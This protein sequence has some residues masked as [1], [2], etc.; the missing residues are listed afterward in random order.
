MGYEGLLSVTITII[1]IA[2]TWWALLA[3][4]FDIFT[5]NAKSPQAKSL[6]IILSIVLGYQL[7]RFFTDYLSWSINIRNLF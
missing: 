1:C 4:R 2:L 3:V 5:Y 6:Q 7:A